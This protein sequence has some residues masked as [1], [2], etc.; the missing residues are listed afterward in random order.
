MPR[1]S[2]AASLAAIV[3]FSAACSDATG[4]NGRTLS[5][6]FSTRP[7]PSAQTARLSSAPNFDVT[8][9]SGS[10]TLV[11]TR[12]QLV[13][14]EIELK[15]SATAL[16]ADDEGDD[17]CEELSL[18]PALVDLPLAAGVTS[19]FRVA[20]PDGS[21]SEMEF[22]LDAVDAGESGAAAFLAA[23]P[24]LADVSVRIEGTYNGR[25]FVYTSSV[26]AELELEFPTP[27]VMSAASGANV[28]VSVDVARWFRTSDGAIVDPTSSSSA[29]IIDANIKQ[30]FHAFEDDDRDGDE[31]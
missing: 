18:G 22:E 6:S 17:D 21:Y 3:T 10:D 25:P 26:D 1:T 19:P 30:S 28:T 8:V 5:L 11:L 15:S 14:G 31:D 29:S 20:I 24:E 27:V 12:A 9:G 23:H 7:A 2:Y 13:L 16:C 4:P